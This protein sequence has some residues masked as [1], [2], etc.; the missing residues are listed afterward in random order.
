MVFSCFLAAC[1]M[2][3]VSI[4]NAVAAALK[5]HKASSGVRYGTAGFRC[6]ASKLLGIAFRVGVL[7]AVRSLNKVSFMSA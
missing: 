7:A 4:R 5:E 2:A 6:Q 1:S 3:T